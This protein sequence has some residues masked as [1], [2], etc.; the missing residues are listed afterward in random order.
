M[1]YFLIRVGEP[2]VIGDTTHTSGLHFLKD[3]GLDEGS[4]LS[5]ELVANDGFSLMLR[6]I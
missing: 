4:C 5:A 2:A 1:S 3:I 6:R